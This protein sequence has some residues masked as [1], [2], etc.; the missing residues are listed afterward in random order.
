MILFYLILASQ[1]EKLFQRLVELKC[2]LLGG[3][4]IKIGVGRE[5]DHHLRL[6]QRMMCLD[7][8]LLKV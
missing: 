7:F 8:G 1:Y 3:R 6:G 5:L 4:K 2:R